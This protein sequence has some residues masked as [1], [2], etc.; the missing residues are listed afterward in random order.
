[1]NFKEKLAPY[2]PAIVM[3]AIAV[4]VMLLTYKD[5]GVAW[6]EPLQ[7][8]PGLL[9]YNYAFHGNQELFQKPN[10]NHGAGYEIPLVMLE[11]AFHLTDKREI[12]RMRHVV[13]HLLFLVSAFSLYVLA[14]RLFKNK[15]VAS[16]GFLMLVCAPR[17]Y[18]HSYFN[19]KDIPFLSMF[20][21]TLAVCRLAFDKDKG[22]L[23]FLVG[24]LCG[25]A[26]SIRIMGV[27]LGLFIFI[28]LIIDLV[29]RL[30]KKERLEKPV[31]NIVLY[32]AGFCSLLVAAWPYL[33][34]SPVH[35]FVES[36]SKLSRF[37]LW[38]GSVMF[39]GTFFESTKLP[40]SYLP[41]WFFI[42]NPVLW[43][44][45]GFAGM[46]WIVKDFFSDPVNILKDKERRNYILYVAC[47]LSPVIAVYLFHSIIYDDWRHLYFIYPS[48]IMMALF[49]IN[50]L[51]KNKAV[52][53]NKYYT[54][55]VKGACGLQLAMVIFFMIQSHPLQQV[56]FNEFVSHED[57]NL[58]KNYEMDYWGVSNY[59]ALKYILNNDESKHIFVTTI[60]PEILQNN[61]DEL[62][63]DDRSRVTLVHPDSADYFITN[64]RFHPDDFFPDTKEYYSDK[65]L[66]STVIKVYTN[67][68]SKDSLKKA[69]G[70]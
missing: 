35:N 70:N 44:I 66:G 30:A 57:E 41:T 1:M 69:H 4:I 55:A 46:V 23:F 18:A 33:W 51:L 40:G 60:F 25:Y 31:V 20:I 61:I 14:Y 17:L 7:R 68:N 49:F 28:Y 63:E 2:F 8:G 9:S 36:F 53:K 6:D 58:R 10:D 43:L 65:V 12:F 3:F 32:I 15:F 37:E 11:K 34:K 24:L 45:A 22:G 47:F 42:T 29:N 16:I 62:D 39:G 26:T 64:F 19:S 5:Y 54:W 38:N 50:K 13:T 59:Q 48:F 52:L 21:I 67:F 27:M 56:Y